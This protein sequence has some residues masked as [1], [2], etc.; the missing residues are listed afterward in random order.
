M[1]PR[2]IRPPQRPVRVTLDGRP[3]EADA[4]ATLC[5]ALLAEGEWALAR[6]PKFHRPRGPSCLRGGCDGCLMRVD[7]APNVMTCLRHAHEGA[8]VERQNVA[9]SPRLDVLRATDWF[10]PRGMNH[11]E[12]FA[13]VPGIQSLVQAFARRVSGLGELPEPA[14]SAG[15]TAP[16]LETVEVD[17]LVVGA[18]LAGLLVADAVRRHGLTVLV[19]DDRPT[20]GGGARGL[21]VARALDEDV[22]RLA[23]DL[24][25]SLRVETTAFGVLEGGDWLLDGVRP[26][27]GRGVT[28]VVARHHVVA[29]GG[30]DPTPGFPGNDMPG[31]LSARAALGLLDQ[32]VLVGTDLV[33]VGDGPHGVAFERAAKEHG[34]EVRRVHAVAAARGLSIVKGASVVERPGASESKV[35]CDAIVHDGPAAP[36]FELAVQAGAAVDHRPA[37]YAVR[38]DEAGRTAAPGLYALGEVTGAALDAEAFRAAAAALADAISAAGTSTRA[39]Q[40]ATP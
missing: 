27:A 3:I 5:A 2:R 32:G 22:D 18:G 19:V 24:G 33:V 14:G 36:C 40:G 29:T 13:G 12:M 23:A 1:P 38:V 37:G 9:L 16:R 25:P 28:R 30:H 15:S 17:V 6:S 21:R 7:D 35:D 34:A 39:A 11:H 31:V 10:F 26:G 8:K 4:A 20:P